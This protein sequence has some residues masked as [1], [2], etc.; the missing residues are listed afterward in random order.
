M[1][2]EELPYD[3]PDALLCKNKKDRQ[4]STGSLPFLKVYFLN[5]LGFFKKHFLNGL[6]H[7]F[8]R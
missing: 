7:I 8:F 2:S 3:L 5:R 1:P 4:S 6:F